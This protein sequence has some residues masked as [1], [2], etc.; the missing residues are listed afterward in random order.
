MN[1][2][3]STLHPWHVPTLLGTFVLANLSRVD[4]VPY[5]GRHA[6]A[7]MAAGAALPGV[8][9]DLRAVAAWTGPRIQGFGLIRCAPATRRASVQALTLLGSRASDA[10]GD[11]P[12]DLQLATADAVLERLAGSAGT[13]GRTNLVARVWE[14]SPYGAVFEAHGFVTA[15]IEYEYERPPGPVG[16]PPV[17][18]GLRSQESPDAW[19]VMQLYRATTPASVQRAEARTME[20]L[21]WV[22]AGKAGSR[23]AAPARIERMLVS[24]EHGLVAWLELRLDAGDAHQLT[25]MLHPRGYDLPNSLVQ[26]ALWRLRSAPS[27]PA[28]IRIL[29]PQ[30]PIG[31]A[32]ETAGFVPT[33]ARALMV[34]DV[35][36]RVAARVRGVVLDGATG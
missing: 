27:R 15:A 13:A 36:E 3:S 26:W 21:E 16:E 6:P 9:S 17:I 35:A 8:A 31:T 18:A 22:P 32:L 30:S 33:S 4:V 12:S 29:E 14:A 1:V 10:A 23:P 24:D 5:H 11:L 20:E 28:R 34:K 19:D 25:L 7:L 2:T